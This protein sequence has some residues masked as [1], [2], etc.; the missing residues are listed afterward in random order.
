MV[1][2]VTKM[3]QWKRKKISLMPAIALA[4][5]SALIALPALSQSRLYAAGPEHFANVSVRHGDNLWSIADRYTVAG[6]SVQ[7]T[8]DQIMAAN[9]KTTATVVPGEHL[10][11]PR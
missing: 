5:L 1:L 8:V 2:E 9:G 11:I 7:D 3:L 4:A 6:Q 10:K